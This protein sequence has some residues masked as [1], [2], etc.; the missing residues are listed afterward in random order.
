MFRRF[1]VIL[2]VVC[3]MVAGSALSQDSEALSLTLLHTNDQHAAHAP[4]AN[5]DGGVAR[6]A[7]VVNQVRAAGGNVLLLDGGDRFTGTL[8]HQQYRGADQVQIMNLLGYD[9][10]VLGNHE[11]DDGD[12][13]LAAF[14][15]GV[16]FP[17]LSAN[18]SVAEG[19]PLDG[20]VAPFTIL[21]AG[22]QRVGVIG[23]TTADTAFIASPGEGT[24]F[25]TDYAGVVNAAA[26]ELEAQGI[27]KII[28]LTHIGYLEDVGLAASLTGV[29][30]II[31]GHS[32]TLMSNAYTAAAVSEYPTVAAD[33]TGAPLLIVQAGGGNSLYLGRLDVEFDADGVLTRWGGDTIFLSQYI[34]PDPTLEALVNDLAAPIEEL[35]RTVIGQTS[36]FLV[37]DRAACR[38]ME[39]TLGNLI[40]DAMR[41]ATGAQ[42]AITNGGGI[43][44]SIPNTPTPEDVALPSPI[45]VTLGDVLTVLPFGNLVSTFSLSGADVIAALEHGLSALGTDAGTG[46]FPQVSGLRFTFDITQPVGSRIVSVEVEGEDGSFS[47]IDPEAI[48]Y[49]ASNDFMRNGGDGY[50]MFEENAINPY[51]FGSPLDQ[52]LAD[53]IRDHSPVAPVLEGRIN[54]AQ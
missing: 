34:T 10:M 6:A 3:L 54:L 22:G 49:V 11:F 14:I 5:G 19:S 45:D 39:C 43:R 25:S 33:S 24:E 51:D 35:R 36:V 4:N 1:L 16:N 30:I 13:V 37:G 26:A 8:F 40:T 18:L 32:H 48:Y 28:L 52:V 50:T 42:I 47:P 15:D 7:S 27:N 17:V 20:K 31:G 29:D 21:E 38:A 53:Y 23:L 9:A 2:T 12:D 41:E 46:R 44:A